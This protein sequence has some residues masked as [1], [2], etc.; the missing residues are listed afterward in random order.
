MRFLRL[1]LLLSCVLPACAQQASEQEVRA[2]FDALHMRQLMSSTMKTMADGMVPMLDKSF[3]DTTPMSPEDRKFAVESV[4]RNMQKIFGEDYINQATEIAIPIYAQSMS[5]SEIKAA[6]EFF[7]SPAGQS[8]IS[9]SPALQ[10]QLMIKLQPIL[11]V[12][13]D[14]MQKAMQHDIAEHMRQ[15]QETKPQPPSSSSR[16]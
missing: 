1:A 15:K 11:A 6:T 2:L 16:S 3:A 5:S 13:M 8:W 9:K 14:E 7:S 10:Q 4:Q 12:K